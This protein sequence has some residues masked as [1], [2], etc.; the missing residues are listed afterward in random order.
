MANM[1]SGERTQFRPRKE[2]EDQPRIAYP[3]ETDRSNRA[4]DAA[5]LRRKAAK[6][7]AENSCF[8]P[9]SFA[10]LSTEEGRRVL[11][12]LRIHQIEL[13]MQNEELR[14]V[15]MELEVSRARYFDLYDLAP[16][17]YC[18]VNSKGLI[19]EANLTSSD[20]I[21]IARRAMVKRLFSQ[22][23]FP[24]DQDI[25]YRNLVLLVKTSTQQSCEL[26]IARPDGTMFWAHL[27]MT[28]EA[29][30]DREPVCRIVIVDITERKRVEEMLAKKEEARARLADIVESAGDAIISKNLN[31]IV[32]SWNQSA[33]RLFGYSADEIIGQP[34]T[35][36]IPPDRAAEEA[37][38]L[39]RLRRGGSIDHYETVRIDKSG[40]R[41]DV[42]VTLST[43]CD[44]SG[45]VIG[46]ST[47]A[48]NITDRK[49]AEQAMRA[50]EERWAATLQSIG[51]A[52]IS[53]D[54]T[55]KVDF[56]NDVA[57]R[58][59]GWSLSE[60]KG[61]ELSAIFNIV[62]EVTR[63][64]PE[65]PVEKVI[66]SGKVVGAANHTV[67]IRRDGTEIPVA[68]RGAPIRNREGQIEGVVLVFTDVSEQRKIEKTLRASDRLATT[69]RL[70]ATIA[71]EIHNPLDSVGNL[72]FLIG[73]GAPEETTREYVSMA[74]QEL[75]RVT[76]LTQQLLTFQREAAKPK[77]VKIGEILDSV[78]SLY[79]RK[80][81]SAG[82]KLE[83]QVDFD[84]HILALPGELRQVFANLVGNAIEAMGS[85]HGT[86][87]LRA[88]E[89]RDWRS[90]RPG[91]RVV[92][93]DDGPGIPASVRT[94]IFEPFFT[95]KGESGTGLGLWI[96]SDILRKYDGTMRLRT[97]TQASHSGTC[98]SVFF[99]F[100]IK[101]DAN[102]QTMNG[103]VNL[104]TK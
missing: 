84:G 80:I 61:S 42:S 43:I 7:L 71:H 14:R 104:G 30:S 34:I 55:G 21:G 95:T 19:Q 54:A 47:S 36:I 58:L 101:P 6:S 86:I 27:A 76:H 16:V 79:D 63:I 96:T 62:Q 48:R 25:Y 39:A 26:R 20:L 29:G 44:A 68:D 57:Q 3:A 52:V 100:E 13:E 77:P 69:G 17:G 38:F 67:L 41:I 88:F 23:I 93:A 75:A 56:M 8:S 92:V 64:K 51:D 45:A 31:G 32:S 87:T 66:R 28:G 40:R 98:F 82:V 103:R 4:E 60:A 59:T 11:E 33:E 99:P 94:S 15:R 12:E 53:T 70:A 9:E 81:Q 85:R 46:I 5:N 22:F 91:L 18:M 73:Q 78:V 35:L 24:Q 102:I 49:Q 37:A 89:S 1:K 65:S 72:L 97:S 90:D 50:S 2:S 10:S 74:G 83:Q